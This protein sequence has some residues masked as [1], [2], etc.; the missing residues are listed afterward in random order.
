MQN[1]FGGNLNF[2]NLRIRC[3]MLK[4]EKFVEY[5]YRI[6]ILKL[7]GRNFHRNFF[8]EFLLRRTSQCVRKF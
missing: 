7:V 8:L 2:E 4:S 3:G 5:R 1:S 6:A